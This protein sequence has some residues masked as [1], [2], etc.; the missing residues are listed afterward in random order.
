MV[1]V[2]HNIIVC[3]QTAPKYGFYGMSHS[4]I[5]ESDAKT[6]QLTV[7]NSKMRKLVKKRKV[8]QNDTSISYDVMQG[9]NHFGFWMQIP[10]LHTV[11]VKFARQF[12]RK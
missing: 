8:H 10:F 1:H 3:A 6:K 11:A 2:N 7:C 12:G 4:K 5:L 9:E